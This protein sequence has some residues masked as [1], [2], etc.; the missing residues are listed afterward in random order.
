MAD[1]R[2]LDAAVR[3]I[4]SYQ[5]SY[6]HSESS[7]DDHCIPL[8]DF[9][10][11]FM[12]NDTSPR[13]LVPTSKFIRSNSAQSWDEIEEQTNGTS[14]DL[15][16]EV[17]CIEIEESRTNHNSESSR[18]SPEDNTEISELLMHGHEDKTGQEFVSMP[19]KEDREVRYMAP[20]IV[21]SPEKSS[22]WALAKYTCSSQSLKL[23]KSRSC[24]ASLLTS[25]STPRFDEV[26][27]YE[28]TPPNGLEKEFTGR[29][30]NIRRKLA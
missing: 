18:S 11:T 13:L 14:D 1:P 16:K 24:N 30:E 6:G 21:P 12:Q 19:V 9:E 4:D 26:G 7:S 25:P 2:S 29:P 17:R 3:T 8:P 20:L 22:P 15:C 5:Y 23:T 10:E 27:N 28:N